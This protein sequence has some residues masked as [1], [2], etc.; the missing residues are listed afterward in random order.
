M[1]RYTNIFVASVAPA[2][3]LLGGMLWQFGYN[4]HTSLNVSQ[5]T[6]S[7]SIGV[8]FSSLTQGGS[9]EVA[10]A[11]EGSDDLNGDEKDGKDGKDGEDGGLK[12][13][14]DSVQLG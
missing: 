12:G 2:A 10:A 11:D 1:S 4:P 8:A 14:W 9:M 3:L 6:F 7:G 13:L 5:V